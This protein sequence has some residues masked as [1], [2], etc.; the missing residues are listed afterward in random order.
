MRWVGGV[1]E[2]GPQRGAGSRPVTVERELRVK[3]VERAVTESG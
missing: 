1:D 2:M 3:R